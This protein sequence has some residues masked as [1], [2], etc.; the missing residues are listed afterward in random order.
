MG[1][2]KNHVFT[3][4]SISWLLALAIL[5]VTLL[6]THYHLHHLYSADAATHA[7]VIDL[8]LALDKTG[9]SHHEEEGSITASPD[10]IMKKSNAAFSLFIV[11]AIVL[12]LLPIL[13]TRIII[14]QD[15]KNIGL[16]QSYPYFLPLL[17]APPLH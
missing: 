4:K 11:L 2:L 5:L 3:F 16:K 7:H 14:R 6:P 17:R 10:G 9:Q 13:K 12:A 15:H 8:H 1:E